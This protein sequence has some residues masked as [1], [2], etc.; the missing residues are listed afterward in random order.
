MKPKIKRKIYTLREFYVVEEEVGFLGTDSFII[1]NHEETIHYEF[2][3]HDYNITWFISLDKALNHL[4]R[5][6][7]GSSCYEKNS[8][9][10]YENGIYDIA[11]KEDVEWY[12]EK[13]HDIKIIRRIK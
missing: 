5:A 6:Y 10:Y 2:L 13:G 4:V 9:I 7:K 1:K 12:I 11:T 3:Y 8:V